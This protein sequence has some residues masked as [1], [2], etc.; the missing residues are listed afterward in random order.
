MRHWQ[1]CGAISLGC[2]AG[3]GV[4]QLSTQSMTGLQRLEVDHPGIARGAGVIFECA[5]KG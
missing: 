2:R 5:E 4:F 3:L 1:D